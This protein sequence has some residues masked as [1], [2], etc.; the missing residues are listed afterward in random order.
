LL[1]QFLINGFT[2]GCLIVL[3][4]VGLALIQNTTR[5]F[6]IAHGAT[7]AVAAYACHTVAVRSGLG[8][9][10]AVAGS[11]LAASALGV[12]MELVVYAP[13]ARRNASP[14]VPLISSLG[15]YVSCVNLI[16]LAFG[17]AKVDSPLRSRLP[18]EFGP[19]LLTRMQ[20][21]EVCLTGVVVAV[22]L[23]WLRVAR[24]GRVICAVRD[25]PVLANVLGVNPWKVRGTVFLVGSALAG[26]A[27][28][29]QTLDVGVDPYVGMH[30]LLTA[31][32]ATIV[33]G[34]DSFAGVVLGG[35]FLG[36]LQSI[37]FW[38]VTSW[39]RLGSATGWEEAVTFLLLILFLIARPEG[40]L[41]TSRR[42][43]ERA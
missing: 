22:V 6:H 24:S 12:T 2:E 36:L 7:Y 10:A 34:K 40:L 39:G 27:A 16:A 20:A 32:V 31:A 33:G 42:A 35:L 4:G 11:L 38:A 15:L 18:L 9:L 41:R 43:E 13:L 23:L 19:L 28:S 8:I 29:L 5:I 1:F 25:H 3:T 26:L 30:V 14:L 17:S 21:A 37:V